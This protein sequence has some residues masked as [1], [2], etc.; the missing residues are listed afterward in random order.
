MYRLNHGFRKY[1]GNI[2]K[3]LIATAQGWSLSVVVISI[4]GIPPYTTVKPWFNLFVARG[5]A[6]WI[7]PPPFISMASSDPVRPCPFPS[8]RGGWGS[9]TRLT[10]WQPAPR[11]N[12]K[13]KVTAQC[14][15]LLLPREE[16]VPSCSVEAAAV[17]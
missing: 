2:P 3:V 1:T 7:G 10:R 17:H 11:S 8:A 6:N 12:S 13:R 14:R 4:E 15:S 9:G 5:N 16:S